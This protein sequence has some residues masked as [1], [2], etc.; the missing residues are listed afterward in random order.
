MSDELSYEQVLE[1]LSAYVLGALE[2][3]EMLAVDAYLSKY[4]ALLARLQ[5]SE[6]AA[7]QLAHLAPMAPLPPKAKDRLFKRVQADLAA[8][9]AT[10]AEAAAI[11][12]PATPAELSSRS[13]PAPKIDLTSEG[14]DSNWLAN[15][16]AAMRATNGWALAMACLL[17]IL[18][19][20]GIYASQ[21]QSQIRQLAADRDRLNTEI[22]ELRRQLEAE[23][24]NLNL[25]ANATPLLVP[26]TEAAPGARAIV[27]LGRND[28]ALVALHGLDPLPAQQTYQLWL[29]TPSQETPVPAGLL[30]IKGDLTTLQPIQ[31][32]PEGRDFTAIG[33][34]IEPAGGSQAPTGP[35]VLLGTIG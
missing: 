16:W 21:V 23:Q 6:Q 14:G 35:I 19:G 11:A 10:T 13:Q 30:E 7:A 2:P 20:V 31:I 22:L 1:R 32:P 24:N 27:Y 26:G 28:Q 3:E 29:I 25:I 9:Q 33:V 18:V 15:F 4:Q 12:S 34:S 17:L 8:Q 5:K